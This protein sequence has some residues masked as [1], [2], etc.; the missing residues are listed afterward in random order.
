MQAAVDEFA[1]QIASRRTRGSPLK[2]TRDGTI[3][4]NVCRRCILG[5]VH[6]QRTPEITLW[7]HPSVNIT[8]IAD[9]D[10]TA[11]RLVL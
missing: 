3:H 8:N 6:C 1:G 4:L 7:D 10:E 5:D 9:I 11:D 2:E